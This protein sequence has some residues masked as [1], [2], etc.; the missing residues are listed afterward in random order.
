MFLQTGGLHD[1]TEGRKGDIC[2]FLSR[3]AKPAP[4][5]LVDV[6]VNSMARAGSQRGRRAWRRSEALPAPRMETAG[7]RS[8]GVL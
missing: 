3:K 6:Y 1:P 5:P 4:K 8:G 7:Q 2:S